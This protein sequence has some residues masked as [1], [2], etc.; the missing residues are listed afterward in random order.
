ML[1]LLLMM[2]VPVTMFTQQIALDKSGYRSIYD[3]GLL[4][5]S[6]VTWTIHAADLG[7]IKREPAWR[8]ANDLKAYGIK[9]KH[10]DYNHTGYHRGHLCAAADR[11]SSM[12]LMRSTFAMSNV[13]PQVPAINCGNWKQTENY[14]RYAAS[15]YDS[16]CVLACPV[17]LDRDT[18]RIGSA[19]LAVPHA[20]FKA[21]WVAASDSVLNAWF[22]FNK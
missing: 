12:D 18:S 22:I 4:C 1:I 16:V 14:C 15:L 11:S 20:F 19:R 8:F 6:Q 13:A 17:F 3:V 21:V 2:I 5:P 9:V 10:S 7:D